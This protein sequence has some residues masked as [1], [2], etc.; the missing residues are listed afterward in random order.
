M[1]KFQMQPCH[2]RVTGWKQNF[3]KTGLTPEMVSVEDY[4]CTQSQ[5]CGFYQVTNIKIVYL[6]N[7]ANLLL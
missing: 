2:W 7:S 5:R 1:I 3:E 6:T 4:S